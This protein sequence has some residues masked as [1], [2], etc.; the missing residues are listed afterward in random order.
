MYQN[1]GLHNHLKI[2]FLILLSIKNKEQHYLQLRSFVWLAIIMFWLLLFAISFKIRLLTSFKHATLFDRNRR[3]VMSQKSINSIFR[4]ITFKLLEKRINW[5]RRCARKR[6]CCT[7]SFFKLLKILD[8]RGQFPHSQ[9]WSG[10]KLAEFIRK[11]QLLC[12]T[13]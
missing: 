3:V 4:P 5:C 8:R 9:W 1:F 10:E 2:S 11:L 12:K 7:L 6:W 13:N